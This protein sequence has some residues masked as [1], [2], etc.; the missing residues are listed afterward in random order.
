MTETAGPPDNRVDVTGMQP[1]AL[2][3]AILDRVLHVDQDL[4]IMK[5]G[6]QLELDAIKERL[7]VIE[8]GGHLAPPA[9]PKMRDPDDSWYGHD[10]AIERVR[11]VTHERVK[12][13][14]DP[15]NSDRV[16]ELAGEMLEKLDIQKDANRWRSTFALVKRA[17]WETFKVA[18]P[19]IIV[20]MTVL[21][22]FFTHH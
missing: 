15:L 8:R 4:R 17:S 14:R 6:L 9:L 10:D 5:L 11:R 21:W 7:A 12:D 18:L 1:Q 2:L 16:R 3:I 13:P 22:H 19:G 20:A